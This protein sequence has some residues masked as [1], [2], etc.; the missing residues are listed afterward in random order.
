[1][2]TR[3]IIAIIS[4]FLLGVTG[5]VILGSASALRSNDLG[6]NLGYE[7]RSLWGGV[8]VQ[9][10]PVF[11][12]KVPGSDRTRTLIPVSNNIKTKLDLEHRHKGLIWLNIN[13]FRVLMFQ[14][15][16]YIQSIFLVF[17]MLM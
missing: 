2:S 16:S 5:W 15:L 4:V 3:R 8:I 14:K 12:T 9:K 17:Q 7:I 11:Y 1:M 6:S 13:T 10:A